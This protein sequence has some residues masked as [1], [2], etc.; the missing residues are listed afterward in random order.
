MALSEFFSQFRNLLFGSEDLLRNRRHQPRLALDLPVLVDLDHSKQP[1]QVRDFG[2]NGLRLHVP[3]K[4]SKNRRLQ[5]EVM[6]DSGLDGSSSLGCRVAWCRVAE[7]GFHIGCRY[8]DKPEVL[9]ASWVQML[10]LERHHRHKD[11]RD[12]RVEAT[13]PALLLDLGGPPVSVFVLDLGLGGARVYSPQPW[14]PVESPR[15]SFGIPGHNASVDFAV[16]VVESRLIEGS[17]YSYRLRFLDP[18]SKRLALLRRMLMQLLEGVRK[19]GRNRPADVIPPQPSTD[20]K[21]STQASSAGVLGAAVRGPL[22]PPGRK[23]KGVSKY[24]Q[25]PKLPPSRP[26]VA[27]Q[28][29]LPK[30]QVEVEVEDQPQKPT[31]QPAPPTGR[32]HADGAARMQLCLLPQEPRERRRGWLACALEG[33]FPRGELVSD[34]FPRPSHE[35]LRSVGP[36]LP[37]LPCL[38]SLHGWSLDTDLDRGFVVGPGL[39]WADRRN[40][41]RWWLARRGM[42]GWLEQSLETRERLERRPRNLRQCAFQLLSLLA[43]GGPAAVRQLLICSQVSVGIARH[44]GVDDPM[45]L[46]QLRLAAML[47]DVGEALLFVASQ[48][49][50]IRD[51]YS[52]HLNGVDHGEPDLADLTADWSGFECPNEM[53]INRLRLDPI[54]LELLPSHPWVG[55]RLLARLGFPPEVRATVRYHHEAWGGFGFPEG[56]GETDIPWSAR[57]LAV[58]DGFASGLTYLNGP[59]QA[60]AEIAQLEGSFYDPGLITALQRYLNELGVIR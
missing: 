2:P 15:L 9:A 8:D 52:L 58:A 12:R 45:L 7:G 43:C 57:C 48:E 1:A 32:L 54:T 60:Y 13:I 27:Q 35:F 3:I 29:P 47:K 38:L 44:S 28:Q 33:W 40:L 18:D 25:V 55:D 51:R 19:A 42:I 23:P 56:L 39:P 31:P 21:T 22:K 36:M 46:N 37:G 34:F 14:S 17:G 59:P 41:C 20:P 6:P 50:S 10:L 11:R 24:L 16:E 30:S 26:P 49:R 5:V 53:L 4:L